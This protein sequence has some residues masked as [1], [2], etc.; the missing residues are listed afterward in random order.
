MSQRSIAQT[1]G[2]S[3]INA[4]GPFEAALRGWKR[5]WNK[6]TFRSAHLGRVL[7]YTDGTEFTGVT[8]ALG[9]IPSN[10]KD[11]C[12]GAVY[13]VSEDDLGRL[14]RREQGYER[15]DVSTHVSWAEKQESAHVITYV[16]RPEISAQLQTALSAN[17]S[18]VVMKNYLEIIKD[19]FRELG[20]AALDQYQATTPKPPWPVEH[21]TWT[22]TNARAVPTAT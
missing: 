19:G 5:T 17:A 10:A 9:L 1:V 14:D 15:I 11:T 2:R 20:E 6:P 13:R 8:V 3:F 12:I 16:P 22:E 21:L 4:E 7:R 18:V